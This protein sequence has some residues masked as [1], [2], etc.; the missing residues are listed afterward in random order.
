MRVFLTL[1][2][3]LT[4]AI[5]GAAESPVDR[6]MRSIDSSKT[7]QADFTQVS[8]DELGSPRHK[9]TG[10]FYLQKPGKFRWDYAK[11]YKQQVITSN[12]KVWFYDVDLE[13]VTVK[14]M[15]KAIGSTPALLLTGQV[16]LKDNFTLEQQ[17]EDEGITWVKLL[18]K[19]EESTFKYVTIGLQGDVLS[20]MELADN[21]GQLTRI[22]FSNVKSGGKL[23]PALFEFTAP[24]GVD[25]FEDQ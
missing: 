16:S 12:G 24:K 17:G 9:A 7:L 15:D 3:L 13:Q 20:G 1:A 25:V 6:L 22:Y 14:R 19:G 4:A 10:V 5:A 21:F 23:D 8:V 2:L 11:P 18:P